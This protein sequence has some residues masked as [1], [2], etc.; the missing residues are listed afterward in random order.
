VA[1]S[2]IRIPGRSMDRFEAILGSRTMERFREATR[3]SAERLAGR[4]IWSINSTAIG[5][6][7]SEMLRVVLSYARGAGIHTRWIVIKGE[8]TFF[9]L[10]KRLHHALHGSP[11][12]GTPL[13]R[14][15]REL[16]E[17]TLRRNAEYLTAWIRPRDVV[18]LHDPQTAG[19]APRL[20]RTG[21]LV[22]WRSHVGS[23]RANDE[24]E[25]GWEFLRP[26]LAPVSA[27]VFTRKT[28]VP[29]YCDHAKATIIQPSIDAFAPK[30][31]DLDERTVRS[32]LV[33]TGLVEAP[34]PEPS[35]L[36]FR[37]H[38]DSVGRVQRCA[39]IVRLGRAPSWETPLVVQ[40]GRWD[41]LKD[42]I[43]AMQ[44]FARL[45]TDSLPAAP[46]LVLAGPNVSGVA[47]D[48]EGAE[49]YRR[50]VA[51]YRELPHGVRARVHL[52]TLPT[53]DVDENAAIV[54]ALQRHSA[55]VVQKSLAEGFGLTVTEAMWK[56]RPVLASAV[57]GIQD[58]IQDGVDG[59]LIRDPTDLEAFA[60]ALRGLLFDRD[61]A[62]RIGCAAHERVRQCFLGVRHLLQYGELIARLDGDGPP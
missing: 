19:L 60:G 33:H 37:R 5:G 44:G 58:Q 43:G 52:A 21:A 22:I 20:V 56:H 24:V 45:P 42:P 15:A 30:N 16:Y 9:R 14:A 13:D 18:L 61:C 2:E 4:A 8:P 41:P 55:V 38:D 39:D 40:V 50:T 10:T 34:A 31:Q 46:E 51:A 6:G 23:D 26:Y 59:I 48:P 62:E 53:A 47:D 25:R 49:T 3:A 12:D 17:A 7:V 27:Y 36:T 57:G 28:Y 29:D 1:P 54:N 32:I 11:G 35:S